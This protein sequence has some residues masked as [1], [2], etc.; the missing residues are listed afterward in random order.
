[1]FRHILIA[2]VFVC[3][4]SSFSQQPKS[5]ESKPSSFT[6]RVLNGKTGRPVTDE[7]PN[8]WFDDARDAFNIPTNAEGEIKVAIGNPEP[9]NIRFLPN[10]Y[11]DCR[12]SKESVG[13]LQVKIPLAE[14]ISKGI[15][16]HNFCGKQ[17]AEPIP[18]LL[19]M[20]V[21]KRTLIEE[22]RL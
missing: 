19:I 17:H 16:G 2:T 14:I 5:T 15:V 18:G 3:V 8:L 21:R 4:T 13:G 1:M 11:V 20:Y 7:L 6:I 22:M 10:H 12:Y 9:Q